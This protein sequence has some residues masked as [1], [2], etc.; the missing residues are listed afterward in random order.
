MNHGQATPKNNRSRCIIN[1]EK[2]FSKYLTTGALMIVVKT[3]P[4][5]GYRVLAPSPAKQCKKT[6]KAEKLT[7][8]P[9]GYPF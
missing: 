3:E 7:Y 8:P 4:K 1:A 6:R 2:L 9:D 5:V